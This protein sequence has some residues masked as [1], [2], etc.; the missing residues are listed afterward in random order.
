MGW[1]RGR[2]GAAPSRSRSRSRGGVGQRE[3]QRQRSG[4]VAMAAVGQR[5]GGEV[6][7]NVAPGVVGSEEERR[8]GQREAN[9]GARLQMAEVEAA[10]VL[11]EGRRGRE[12]ERGARP[13][14]EGER[15]REGEGN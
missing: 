3:E 14:R 13:D 15:G 2:S 5:R 6:S 10:R 4:A 12:G 8:R 11:E 7:T 9:G 1:G